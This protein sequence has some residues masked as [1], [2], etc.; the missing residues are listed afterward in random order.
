MATST[1][2]RKIEISNPDDLKKLVKVMTSEVPD[3]PLSVHPFTAEERNR[4]DS[5]LKQCL[6]HSNH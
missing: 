4:S 2:E 3:I 6:S 5:L 1:F